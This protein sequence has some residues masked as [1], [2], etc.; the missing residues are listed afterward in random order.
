MRNSGGIGLL[1]R[2]LSRGLIVVVG[3]ALVGA[4]FLICIG[5]S[6]ALPL[7][8]RAPILID[9]DS[10]FT[11]ENG[12]TAGSGAPDDPFII[13]GWDISASFADAIEVRNTRSHFVIRNSSVHDGYPGS[14]SGVRCVNV[15]NARVESLQSSYN[16]YGAW[17]TDATY[18]EVTSSAFYGYGWMG[19]IAFDG[20]SENNTVANNYLNDAQIVCVGSYSTITGNEIWYAGNGISIWG[21]HHNL[22]SANR[23]FSC[24]Y[25]AIILGSCFD[26]VVTMN[27]AAYSSEGISIDAGGRNQISGNFVH[28]NSYGITI[29]YGVPSTENVI[30]ENQ[31]ENNYYGLLISDVPSSGNSIYHN[32][33]VSNWA[34]QVYLISGSVNTWD[35][36]Y[37]SGG[38][39]WSD[40]YG[41]D[42]DGDG[43]GDTPYVID[44]YNQD[45]Y[46]LMTPWTGAIPPVS[47]FTFAPETPVAGE[48]MTFDASA[49]FD[50]DGSIVSYH[51]DF[52]DGSTGDGMVVNHIFAI[53]NTYDVTLTVTDDAGLSNSTTMLVSVSPAPPVPHEVVK[54]ANGPRSS[55][56]TWEYVPSDYGTWT[57][58]IVNS[59]L[60]WL[61]VDVYDNT[62]G[63]MEEVM[64]QKINFRAYGG[65]PTGPFYTYSVVL[66]PSHKYL[67]TVTPNGPR[68]SSAVVTDIFDALSPPTASFTC[69]TDRLQVSV[70][71]TGSYDPD[72]TV[73][74]WLWDWGDGS[75]GSGSTASH[76]YGTSGTYVVTLLVTDD[77]GLFGTANESVWVSAAPAEFF[78]PHSD[79]GLDTDGDGLFDYLAVD[80]L[81]LV[82]NASYYSISGWLAS[83]SW[84]GIVTGGN[85]TY[86]D[87]GLHTVQVLFGGYKIHSS[88]YDGPYYG[89]VELRDETMNTLDSDTHVTQAYTRDQFQSPPAELGPPHSDHGLDAD[90]DGL[91][92]YL[93]VEISVSVSTAGYY[94]FDCADLYDGSWNWIEWADNKTY[95]DSGLQTV[96][97]LFKGD[98]IR[99]SGFNGPYYVSL[100]LCDGMGTGLDSEIYT[101]QAYTWDQFQSQPPVSPAIPA[102]KGA[103]DNTGESVMSLAF[104][105]GWT[106]AVGAQ[107]TL[108]IESWDVGPL[109]DEALLSSATLVVTYF[110]DPTYQ[111]ADPILWAMEGNAW[112]STGIVPSA[113][114]GS[115]VEATFDFFAAGVT[116]VGGLRN[117]D[118]QFT[119]TGPVGTGSVQF[120]RM[121]IVMSL[122]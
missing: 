103:A 107:M 39:Y 73:V 41:V 57:G 54:G 13:E 101:T 42:A 108:E 88:D 50:P 55:A 87:P 69:M 8:T 9:G 62:T 111:G 30:T 31:I 82:S 121:W 98:L 10:Q 79:S 22:I 115:V 118:I 97:I 4:P 56:L 36:G 47:L 60:R 76:T 114:D 113:G 12:V 40:Y 48:P 11:A 6:E 52:G 29:S 72:G 53:E 66:S 3:L 20:V 27:E 74:S 86:L 116:T 96:E 49:A 75:M 34:G 85:Y 61:L 71:G 67:I 44:S 78:P 77:D 100:D 120:D 37:P 70:D 32:N 38:N 19:G 68:G 35:D 33:F 65:L 117:L 99:S 21:Y 7:T 51:W 43:I 14:F 122:Q 24:G 17:L 92:D 84:N 46:P 95:L 112:T 93:V 25:Y 2:I 26:C 5:C 89:Y 1:R 90:G 63:S 102:T 81:V 23:V 119:N 64:H 104:N 28:D 45:S 110:V 59:G 83:S 15:S 91:F 18:S 16:A 80:L 106:Y 105:D 109:A 94:N 58:Q